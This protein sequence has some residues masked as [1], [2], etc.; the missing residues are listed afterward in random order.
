MRLWRRAKDK[1]ADESGAMSDT[2]KIYADV[3]QPA[4]LRH[5]GGSVDCHTLE[6]AVLVWMRLPDDD[7]DEATITVNVPGGPIY[8]AQQIDRPYKKR[9]PKK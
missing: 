9:E 7:R 6:E 3:T 4:T 5:A 1:G 2:D 8:T